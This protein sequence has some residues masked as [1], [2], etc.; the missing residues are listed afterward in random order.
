MHIPDG[1]IPLSQAIVYWILTLIFLVIFF[2]KVSKKGFS[3]KRIILTAILA[4][5]TLV[6]M[7]LSIPSPFGIPMHFFLIPLVVLILGPLNGILISFLVLLVQVLFFG[8]GGITSLGANIFCMGVIIA[9]VCD[10]IYKALL[11]I[12]KNIA[13]FLS[14]FTSIIAATVIQCIILIIAQV[15]TLEILLSSL[16]PFYLFIAA[17]EGYINIIILKF[18]K[19]SKNEILDIERI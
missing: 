9:I 10:L 11:D 16:L 2:K 8:M 17:V 19:K 6:S 12:N 3:S 14:T 4:A 13:I 18:I 7:T 1:F 15:G 5:V